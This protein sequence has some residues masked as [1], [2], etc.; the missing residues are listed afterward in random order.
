MASQVDDLENSKQT[1][2]ILEANGLSVR[3]VESDKEIDQIKSHMGER[4]HHFVRAYRVKNKKTDENFLKYCKDNNISKKDIHFYYHGSKNENYWG[5][6]KD[7]QKLNPNASVCGKMFGYGLY[8]ANKAKK[9]MNYTSISARWRSGVE[10]KGYL[11]V[12]KVAYK[13]PLHVLKYEQ[14]MA[15]I[16]SSKDIMWHDALFAH[17]GLDLINDEIIVYNEKQVSL[18][19][20]IEIK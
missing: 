17:G 20:M 3:L 18:C 14:W 4:K 15:N 7:G 1:E 5:I 12:F 16:R 8:Y 2:T 6:M 11:A 9:S 19:Y 13:N 10:N